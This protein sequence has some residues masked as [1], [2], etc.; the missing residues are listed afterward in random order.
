MN[1]RA[2]CWGEVF[3]GGI[4]GMIARAR[5]QIDPNPQAVRDAFLRYLEDQPPAPYKNATNYDDVEGEPIVADDADVAQIASA[6]ARM[7]LDTVTEAQPSAFP[8]QV[9]LIG[10]RPEWIFSGAFDTTRKF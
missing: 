9:Y 5:P 3:A 6:V 10:L 2:M 4:G 8:S 7:A 1:Y